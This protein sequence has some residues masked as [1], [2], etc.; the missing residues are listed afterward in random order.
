MRLVV[1]ETFEGLC[2]VAR[3]VCGVCGWAGLD[4]WD[5][6]LVAIDEHTFEHDDA[7]ICECPRC[8]LR[9]V[10]VDLESRIEL[11]DAGGGD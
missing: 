7:P 6:N 1:V 8:G 3:G 9:E 11:P 4:Q 2:V 10:R 5:V